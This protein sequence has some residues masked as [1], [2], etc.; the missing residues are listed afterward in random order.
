M[1]TFPDETLPELPSGYCWGS[2]H[3]TTPPEIWVLE[4]GRPRWRL[5]IAGDCL[6]VD[7][8]FFSNSFDPDQGPFP[9]LKAEVYLTFLVTAIDRGWFPRRFQRR[10]ESGKF[11]LAGV[12]LG[13]P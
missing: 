13:A 6:V 1:F 3:V 9:E 11:S 5:Q 7:A 4:D 2:S 8:S 10:V 12:V